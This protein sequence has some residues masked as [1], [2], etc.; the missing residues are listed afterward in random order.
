MTLIFSSKSANA[1]S[2]CGAAAWMTNVL[3]IALPAIA[4]LAILYAP[5]PSHAAVTISAIERASVVEGAGTASLTVYGGVAGA[6]ST[7]PS[8]TTDS[9]C[10]SCQLIGNETDGDT[11]LVACNKKRIHPDLQLVIYLSSDAI[12]GQ[13]TITNADGSSP[14][15]V[16]SSQ[17]AVTKGTAASITLSWRTICA[18]LF[19][20]ANDTGDATNCIPNGDQVSGSFRVGISSS[21]NPDT[22]LNGSKDEYRTVTFIVRREIGQGATEAGVSHAKNCDDDTAIGICQFEMGAGDEKAVVKSMRA[23]NGFPS[24]SNTTFKHVRFL[25]STLGFEYIHAGSSYID[26]PISG[27]DTATFSV[28][29]KRVEGLK[30]DVEHFFK[31][32]VVD[33]AGNVGYYSVALDDDDCVAATDALCRRVTPSEVVGLLSNTNCFIATAAYGGR[34]KDATFGREVEVLREFRDQYLMNTAVGRAFVRAY[35]LASPPLARAIVDRPTVRAMVRGLLAPFVLFAE[36][37]MNRGLWIAMLASLTVL[38][39][40]SLILAFIFRENLAFIFRERI[41][42]KK[43]HAHHLLIILTLGLSTLA[44]LPA[45]RADENDAASELD[46]AIEAETAPEPEFPYPGAK[47]AEFKATGEKSAS[48]GKKIRQARTPKRQP[49]TPRPIAVTEEGEYIYAASD[50]SD[51]IQRGKADKVK[52]SGLEGRTPPQ[53]ITAEGEYLYP[54][55]HS[56]FTGAAGIRIG[57]MAPPNISNPN[58]GLTFK[59]IYGSDPVPAMLF[60]YEYPLSRAIGRIGIKFET[61]FIVRQGQGHFRDP[62]R[63]TETADERFTFVMVPLQASLMYRFQF[64]DAQWVVPFAEGGANYS[65]ITEL[66]DDNKAPR[67][68][69]SPALIA[70]GGVSLLLDWLDRRALSQLDADYGINHVWATVQY[71]QIIGLKKDLD[72]SSNLISAGFT[73]D[74]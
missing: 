56:E 62:A 71:R 54:L 70:G 16:L 24:S 29:P 5:A 48:G 69:G 37:A 2:R 46:K 11:N 18:A 33:A 31:A 42:K 60:E 53:T 13:P 40:A 44:T 55:D 36:L 7:C 72:I 3:H 32:A 21:E 9:T 8:T 26:L 66:R 57:M 41:R 28:S 67:F 63:V 47:D 58:N 50:D 6:V 52:F 4:L 65:G 64:S 45:A 35:Y 17:S 34:D 23:L 1:R 39:S 73:F 22:L 10:D 14:L 59:N 68:G 43:S 27:T 15:S 74:Y 30:N 19:T 51:S 25:F 61:G 20:A 38:F 12:D 49:G